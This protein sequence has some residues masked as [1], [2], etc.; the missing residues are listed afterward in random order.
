MKKKKYLVYNKMVYRRRYRKKGV[1]PK[2]KARTYKRS[3]MRMPRKISNRAATFRR[4]FMLS[5]IVDNAAGQGLVFSFNPTT[6]L[7]GLA[8]YQALWDQIKIHKILY[9]FEPWFAVSNVQSAAP[10][11]RMCRYVHDFDDGTNLGTTEQLYLDYANCKS[12]T[13]NGS[14]RPFTIPLYP[15][16]RVSTVGAGSML[17]KPGYFD[18]DVAMPTF[19]GIKMFVPYLATG[20]TIA[21]VRCTVVFSC[22]N[23]R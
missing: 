9:T 21:N 4:E 15:L 6:D 19:Y 22:R 5:P 8:E 17:K 11:Q 2:R 14:A 18:I 12:R 1:R 10:V 16:V 3:L 20:T 7:P 13:L 23:S